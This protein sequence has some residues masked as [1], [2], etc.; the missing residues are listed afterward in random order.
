MTFGALSI[1]RRVETIFLNTVN[2]SPASEIEDGFLDF[3]CR[4][5]TVVASIKKN[6]T[7]YHC[8]VVLLHRCI[9]TLV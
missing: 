1:H 4:K 3:R 2:D 5:S 8:S 7:D 9:P 6:I